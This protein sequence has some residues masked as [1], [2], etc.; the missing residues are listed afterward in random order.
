[1]IG[2]GSFLHMTELDRVGYGKVFIQEDSAFGGNKVGGEE[3]GFFDSEQRM[4]VVTIP[5]TNTTMRKE[6]S[7]VWYMP[8]RLS[9][10]CWMA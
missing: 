6:V 2:L 8:F 10:K 3:S 5:R 4:G 9:G 1:M 7:S